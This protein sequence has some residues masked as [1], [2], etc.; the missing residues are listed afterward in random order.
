MIELHTTPTANGYRASIALEETGL[1]YVSRSYDLVK[2]EHLAPDFLRLNPV[3]RVPAIV[4]RGS[5]EAPIV[6]FGT[7]AIATYVAEKTGRLLPS[8]P[9]ARAAAHSW[10]GMVASDA[11]PAYSGQFVFSRFAPP[12]QSWGLE[13]FQK[14]CHRMLGALETRLAEVPYLAGDEYSIADVL[15]YPLAAV[16]ALRYPG[17]LAAYPAL[18]AWAE[19][20]G[21]RPAVQR[22]MRVPA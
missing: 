4:D 5:G 18:R 20:V 17:D 1:A 15:A 3:G 22:G 14:Q 2:G 6:V 10:A 13:H 9:V 7:Q 8:D 11:G 19:R 21:A 16:S 12:E